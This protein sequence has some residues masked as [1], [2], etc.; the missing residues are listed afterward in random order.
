VPNPEFCQT[1]RALCHQPS[2]ITSGPKRQ[3]DSSLLPKRIIPFGPPD[4]AVADLDVANDA[5]CNQTRIWTTARS[6]AGFV[7]F[8]PERA[9]MRSLCTLALSKRR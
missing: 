7:F 5:P 8:R 9:D 2:F 4:D 3:I 6:R 1:F